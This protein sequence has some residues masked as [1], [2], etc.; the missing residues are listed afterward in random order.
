MSRYCGC[1][2]CQAHPRDFPHHHYGS[3]PTA[4]VPIPP[5]PAPEVKRTLTGN[6]L[7]DALTEEDRTYLTNLGWE[8][9][10]PAQ[11]LVR[12]M[13]DYNNAAILRVQRR[14]QRIGKT[15][16]ILIIALPAIWVIWV[17]ALW[18]HI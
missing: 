4:Q 18:L 7:I 5:P 12:Y 11:E 16:T 8:P 15:A 1:Q 3:S 10:S 14:H 2:L 13:T 6:A 9:E 17:L